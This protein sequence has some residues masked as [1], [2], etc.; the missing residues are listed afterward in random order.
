VGVLRT[1]LDGEGDPATIEIPAHVTE[2]ERAGDIVVGDATGIVF[3]LLPGGTF[4]MGSQNEDEARPNFDADHQP[5]E[6]M[7]AIALAPFFLGRHELT[8]AQWLRLTNGSK[9]SYHAAGLSPKVGP[10]ITWTNPVESVDWNTFRSELQRHG[11]QL[12]TEAQWE[13]G[14]RAATNGPWSCEFEQLRQFANLA[15]ATAKPVVPGWSCES[16]SDENILHA[17]VGTFRANGFGLFDAHGNVWEWTLDGDFGAV[18]APRAG[19]GLQGDPAVVRN[20]VARGGGFAHGAKVAR[21]AQR[22]RLAP[23]FR[24]DDF[25]VRAARSLID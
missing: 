16:W 11:L 22:N 14:C 12:P 1:A 19:D 9:P 24:S 21:S 7:H 17:A 10:A 13:Y 2:G 8:Q 23:S 25:G 3:V 20:R 15:D 6:A 18:A 4:T 5:D